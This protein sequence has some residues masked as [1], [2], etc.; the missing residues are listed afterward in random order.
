MKK[1]YIFQSVTVEI[2]ADFSF[3]QVLLFDFCFSI[4]VRIVSGHF[5]IVFRIKNSCTKDVNDYNSK[6]WPTINNLIN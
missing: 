2:Q 1:K 4:F 3:I 6:L 5:G